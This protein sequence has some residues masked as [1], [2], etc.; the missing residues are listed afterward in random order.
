MYL[1]KT[2]IVGAEGVKIVR[3]VID[4]RVDA[5]TNTR[6]ER[7]LHNI[8]FRKEAGNITFPPVRFA[9]EQ[10]TIAPEYAPVL[11]WIADEIKDAGNVQLTITGHTCDLGTDEENDVLGM[12]RA[13][14]V[15]GLL[16]SFG[17]NHAQMLVRSKGEREALERS[18]MDYARVRNRRVEI[19]LR[20]GAGAGAGAGAGK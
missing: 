13:E 11:A 15:A 10:S 2:N 14:S 7:R 5:R 19:V 18:Q 20:R 9:Q 4:T 1:V 3:T 16:E 17:V 8:I 12:Q 6:L